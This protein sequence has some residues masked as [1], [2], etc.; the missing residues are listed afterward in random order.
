MPSNSWLEF[1]ADIG[2]FKGIFTNAGCGNFTNSSD[3]SRSCRRIIM[4]F[5]EGWNVSLLTSDK[6]LIQELLT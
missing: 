3:N 2:I 4:K 1:D 5:F 6:P